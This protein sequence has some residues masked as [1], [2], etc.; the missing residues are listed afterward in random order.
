MPSGRTAFPIVRALGTLG[1]VADAGA[2]RASGRVD[3]GDQ[4]QLA[5]AERVVVPPLAVQLGPDQ[6]HHHVVD[7]VV[8]VIGD[9]FNSSS[10]PNSPCGIKIRD[11]EKGS[12]SW[13]IWVIAS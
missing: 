1:R 8:L 10:S 9:L 7:A 12:R 5:G 4:Q 11:E 13:A 3:A 6:R 2:D